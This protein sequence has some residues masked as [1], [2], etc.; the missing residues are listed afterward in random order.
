MKL[1]VTSFLFDLGSVIVDVD[2][3][4]TIDAFHTIF[5]PPQREKLGCFTGEA[6]AGDYVAGFLNDYQ[7]GHISTDQ[8]LQFIRDF[9]YADV[10]DET[11]IDAWLRMLV[12]ISDEVERLLQNI[13]R[14]GLKIYILSNINELHVNWLKNNAPI[15]D[16]AEKCFFSNEI[17]LAKP[18]KACYEYVLA[19]S[20]IVPQETLYV[21]DLPQ[22]IEA[23]KI[24]GFQTLLARDK[25]WMTDIEKIL[26][27]IE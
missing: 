11:I 13:H 2:P 6:L 8:F 19:H 7:V 17:H 14:C 10:S 24:F 25:S 20:D 4:K 16:L 27:S 21:D 22:N 9:C 15:L 18:D 5:T 23:G 26:H 3:Q 12:G 1:R